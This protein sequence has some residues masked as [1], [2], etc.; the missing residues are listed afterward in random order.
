MSLKVRKVLIT[1]ANGFIGKNLRHHLAERTDLQL[2]FF[3]H[4]ISPEKLPELLHGV[5]FVF[6]LAG[7]NRP[8]DPQEYLEG[9]VKLTQ[10]LCAAIANIK[11]STGQTIPVLGCSSTQAKCDTPYGQSKRAGENLL[12]TLQRD[13]AVPV[14][15]FR[16][17]NVFGKW[18]KPNYNSV[19]ATFCHNIAC[20]LPIQI[21]DPTASLTLVY[22][23]D[24]L[25]RF[26]QLMEGGDVVVDDEGFSFVTPVY[27]TTVGALAVQIRAF[28][29]SR[30]TLLTE[31]VGFGLVRALYSTYTSY[32]P[33][34]SFTYPLLQ[35]I[36]ARGRFVEV[37]KT[38]DCGQFSYFTAHPGMTRGGHY[39]HSKTEKF[40]VIKGKARFR[41]R[42]S[43]TG[44]VN[45]LVTSSD[46]P[47]FVEIAPGWTHDIT[48]VGEDEM[49]VILWSNELF[50]PLQPDTIPGSV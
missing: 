11:I 9:N 45:D 14:Y 20:D 16:L 37:L 22:I 21:N 19:V 5:E 33:V 36:D 15:V 12:F 49:V 46:Q 39:H 31:R 4:D 10:S 3:T 26:I 32:L 47:E 43:H 38:P 29:E 41:F 34:T 8:H 48:N 28:K 17:P 35:H 50:N 40:L 24:V 42:H 18:C 1:G 7:I 30:T 2:V 23:D 27:S 13:H 44:E 6:H 25:E